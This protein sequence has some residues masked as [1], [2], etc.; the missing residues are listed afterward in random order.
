[1]LSSF[2]IYELARRFRSWQ[3]VALFIVIAILYKIGEFLMKRFFPNMSQYI[4]QMIV[5][6]A[7]VV[8]CIIGLAIMRI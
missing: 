6:L 1:M 7:V 3:D 8:I 2:A 5:V 4:R